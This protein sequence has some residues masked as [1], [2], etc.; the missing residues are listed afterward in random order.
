MSDLEHRLQREFFSGQAGQYDAMHDP[1]SDEN[2]LALEIL[3][4]ALRYHGATSVLDVGAGTGRKVSLLQE[5]LPGVRVV[6]LEPV[7]ALRDI[8]YA[9]GIDPGQLIEGDALALPFG[10]GEFDFVTEFAV[11]H[12]VREARRAIAEMIRVARRGIFISD[13]NNFGQGSFWART[14][15]QLFRSLGLWPV[16]D[17]VK[18]GGKGFKVSAGDGVAYSFSP[19]SHLRFIARQCP[20]IYSFNTDP[21]PGGHYRSAGH[22]GLLAL[23]RDVR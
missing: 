17:L 16:V 23:K 22:V 6:G 12:H 21:T 1:R 15:K 18:T 20:A 19:Y 5:R 9:G 8:G 7:S 14:G 10:D 11:L 3:A 2:F 4:G 13:S